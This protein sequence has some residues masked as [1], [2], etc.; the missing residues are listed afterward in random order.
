MTDVTMTVNGQTRSASVPPETTL[1]QLL[2][3]NFNLTG[4][5]LGCDVGDCGACTVIVDG[6]AVNSCLMLAGQADGRQV[7]TIEGLASRDRLHPIQKAFEDSGALQC[8]FC[9]PGVLMSAKALL[10]ENPDPSTQEIRDA[11]SG[12]LCRCTGY[13]KMIEAVQDAARVLREESRTQLTARANRGDS[14]MNEHSQDPG[15]RE[16]RHRRAAALSRRRSAAAGD[17]AARAVS[18]RA[19]RRRMRASRPARSASARRGRTAACTASGR[20]STSTISAFPACSTRG[21]SAPAS[22]RRASSSIDTSAA[23]AMP[24]VMAVLT[25]SEIPVNSFGPTFQDQPVLADERVFH[26]GDGVAA[27][28]AVT[29]QIAN[30]ALEKIV[31]EYEPLPAVL[32]P[33]AAMREDSP[34]VHAPNSNIYATKVIRKGDVEKGFAEL[35]PYLRGPLPHPDGRARV[36]RA[37]RGDRRL[38]C[39]RPPHHLGDDRAHHARRAPTSRAR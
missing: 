9:G 19:A 3:D 12:N 18:D 25:G 13:T 8:G 6:Q 37:A 21:S 31:V 20:P 34:K 27:V 32:D 36:A 24:G 28:A 23:E 35:R 5:K 7:L 33:L 15:T 16:A 14:T 22:P 30:E 4:A 1:L 10:D 26:A 29:E 17:R 39:Q 2:R 11:L 38:G